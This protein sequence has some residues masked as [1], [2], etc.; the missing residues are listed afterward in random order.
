[1]PSKHT[2]SRNECVFGRAAEGGKA[3][4]QLCSKNWMATWFWYPSLQTLFVL[5]VCGVLAL[6]P[7]ASK[8]PLGQKNTSGSRSIAQLMIVFNTDL[9]EGLKKVH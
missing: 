4:T 9:I 3:Q 2:L 7:Q 8:K 6:V 1:M 5:K